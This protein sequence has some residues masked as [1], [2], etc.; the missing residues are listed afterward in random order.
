M[1]DVL[2]IDDS[3]ASHSSYVRGDAAARAGLEDYLSL[4]EPTSVQ[5]YVG[6]WHT[7]AGP[8]PPSETDRRAMREMVRRNELPVVLIVAA[9][10]VNRVDVD[11]WA[12]ISA[13]GKL[14]RRTRGAFLNAEIST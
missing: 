1:T 13:H 7:H 2:A 10:G 9:L 11:L 3:T 14:P 6:E 4:L 8:F 5:G 12:L